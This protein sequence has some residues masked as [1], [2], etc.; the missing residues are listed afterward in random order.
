M[1]RRATPKAKAAIRSSVDDPRSVIEMATFGLLQMSFGNHEE[2]VTACEVALQRA[3]DMRDSRTAVRAAL[4]LLI[5]IVDVCRSLD[6]DLLRQT[7]KRLR[8]TTDAGCLGTAINLARRLAR[9]NFDAD[10][11]ADAATEEF[12]DAIKDGGGKLL[13]SIFGEAVE[14]ATKE[15]AAKPG[16][17]NLDV[18]NF[19]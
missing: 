19:I 11:F 15:I 14:Q 5:S 12:R 10:K 17:S 2:G 3:N 16:E 4:N 1:P 8:D 18:V 7:T 9:R 13:G 6:I